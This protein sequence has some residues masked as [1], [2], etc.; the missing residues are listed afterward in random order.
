MQAEPHLFLSV[1]ATT[2][3]RRSNE[4]DGQD[5]HFLSEE[6]FA[7]RRAA[8]AFL[9][10]ATVFGH[11]YGTPRAPIDKALA[12]GRDILFDIDWQG[13]QRL[14]K[15]EPARLVRVFILPPSADALALRLKTRAQDSLEARRRRMR[16]ASGEIQHY[17]EY[18]YVLINRD[19]A[20]AVDGVRAILRAERARITRQPALAHFVADLLRQ[21][22]A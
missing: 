7:A 18:D 4:I 5:Y 2:R 22:K 8:N 12:Q 9:E 10:C 16:G 21:L 6:E 3:P 17:A 13:A 19:L 20:Q 1:S 15:C 11:A 14:A